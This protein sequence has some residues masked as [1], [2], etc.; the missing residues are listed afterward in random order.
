MSNTDYQRGYRAAQH[1]ALQ[2]MQRQRDYDLA[3]AI[4]VQKVE[5]GMPAPPDPITLKPSHD[6]SEGRGVVPPYAEAAAMMA[7]L[8]EAEGL[9]SALAERDE[10]LL[11]LAYELE[12]HAGSYTRAY[13]TESNA[14]RVLELTN[15]DVYQFGIRL[16][17]IVD[18]GTDPGDARYGCGFGTC[19]LNRGHGGDHE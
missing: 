10:S 7:Q 5:L 12:S 6:P 16:R 1:R 11:R 13:G 17:A 8:N 15:A 2:I 4:T 3:A 14:E 9:V 19:S 18:T